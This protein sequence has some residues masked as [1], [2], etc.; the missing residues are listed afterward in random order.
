MKKGFLIISTLLTVQFCIAQ[1]DTPAYKRNPVIPQITL[2]MT[3][4]TNLTNENFKN[5]PIIIMYFSP[6]CDHCQHQWEDMVK[7]MDDLKKFQIVMVT[8]QPYEDM[9]DFYKDRNIASYSN[10][11]MGR[12]IKFVLPPFYQIKS[13]PYLALYDKKGKLITTF[14]GNVT[15][16]KLVEA[17]KTK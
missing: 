17:F 14:E 13:L 10:V 11:K 12:D 4:S 5:Q 1:S 7:R 6:T 8:Y 2:L 3:D 15:V 9:V 16:D